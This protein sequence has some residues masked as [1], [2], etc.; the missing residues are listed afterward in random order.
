MRPTLT[1]LLLAC[2]LPMPAMAQTIV[3]ELD[4]SGRPG[5]IARIVHA[6]AVKQ[7]DEADKDKD[8][9]LTR[10]EVA[11]VSPY[12]GQAFAQFDKNQDGFLDWQEFVGHDRWAK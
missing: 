1:T 7:F 3:P 5:E 4:Q 6:K 2:L 10:E 11:T 8:G 9:R 12:K